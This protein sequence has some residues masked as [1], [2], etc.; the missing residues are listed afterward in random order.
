MQLVATKTPANEA[1]SRP[2][3]T[4]LIRTGRGLMTVQTE[5]SG[6]PAQLVTIVD[7]R[8]RVLKTWTSPFRVE[9]DSAE[10]PV[11]IRRWHGEIEVRVR[12]SLSR[13]SQRKSRKQGQSEA[14][15]H[16]FLA[17]MQAYR[18]RDFATAYGVLRGCELL[19]PEDARIR[20][21]LRR[22][23]AAVAV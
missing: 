15:A 5:I 8:G 19:L 12:E 10:A 7:F 22:L 3:L 6:D 21:A 20:G 11:S 16:L 18:E 14:V 9:L 13:A 23:R 17:A 2:G 4:S 1:S